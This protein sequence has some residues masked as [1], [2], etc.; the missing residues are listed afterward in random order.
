MRSVRLWLRWSWRDLCRRWVQVAA[1]ALI[2]ALG[3]GTYAAMSSVMVWRMNSNDASYAATNMYDVRVKLSA[4]SF[5][6]AGGLKARLA[7]SEHAS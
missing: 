4:G 7:E 1:I 2:I 3:T 5:A 6:E